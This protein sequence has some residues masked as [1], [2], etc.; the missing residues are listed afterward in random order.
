IKYYPNRSIDTSDLYTIIEE[1][2]DDGK[3]VVALI[4]DYI[5]RIRPTER[6]KDEKEELKNITNELKNLAT[7][8]DIPVITAHQLNRTAAS[9]VDAAMEANKEDLGRF[10]GRSNV[11]SAWE[12]IENSDWVC[13]INVERKRSTGQYY[14]TFKRVKIRYR[15][16]NDLGYFNH[17]F[18]IGNRIRLLDDIHLETSLSEESL[19]SDF[20]AVDLS[21]S[22]KKGK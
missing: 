12:V 14:L 22:G 20:D 9:V 18:E 8:L 13:V 3:E 17:P 19:S 2:E 16:P 7:E 4:L 11:G 21:S 6:G 15:D 5:K 1:I 10:I